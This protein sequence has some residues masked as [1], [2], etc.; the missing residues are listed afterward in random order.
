MSRPFESTAGMR[1]TTMTRSFIKAGKRMV[2][3]TYLGS[4]LLAVSLITG[5]EPG[6]APRSK[7]GSSQ[8]APKPIAAS[9][10][11]EVG[12]HGFQPSQ[13]ALGDNRRIV[14]RRTSDATCA[15]AVVFPNLGIQ[16]SLPLNTDVAV[17]LPASAHGEV[18]F[19]CG[20]GMYKSKVVVQ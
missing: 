11:V 18:G 13:L 6:S 7:Q 19:Q 1:A 15:T 2:R 3:P 8:P 16:K 12:A 5:C 9:P 17:D 20:M 10:R 4:L 14:F